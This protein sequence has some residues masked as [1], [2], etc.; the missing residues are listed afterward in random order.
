MAAPPRMPSPEACPAALAHCSLLLITWEGRKAA[1]EVLSLCGFRRGQT[2]W[3]NAQQ[4]TM[5]TTKIK[6]LQGAVSQLWLVTASK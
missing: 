4:A 3:E 2:S 5:G 1:K 6:G